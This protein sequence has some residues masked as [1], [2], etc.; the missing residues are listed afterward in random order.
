MRVVLR[1]SGGVSEARAIFFLKGRRRLSGRDMWPSP[2]GLPLLPADAGEVSRF[3]CEKFRGVHGVFDRAGP[4][5]DSRWRPRP[6]CLPLQSTGVGAPDEVISR[7]IAQP[8][9]A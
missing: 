2:T 4:N 5:G 9:A 8:A 1:L 3:S 6:C 7:S